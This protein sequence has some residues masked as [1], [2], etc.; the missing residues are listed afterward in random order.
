M[1]PC[2]F[3]V[4]YDPFLPLS[5]DF[6]S[7]TCD[8]EI[9]L[10]DVICVGIIHGD[11][12]PANFLAFR[13]DQSFVAKLADFGYSAHFKGSEFIRLAESRPFN[14]PEY[15]HGGFQ[16]DGARKRDIFSLGM[17]CLWILF[18]DVL[19]ET[20]GSANQFHV[21]SRDT[22]Q[23]PWKYG[24]LGQLK[25]E[26][27]L[28]AFGRLLVHQ[29]PNLSGRQKVALNRFL[30]LALAHDPQKRELNMAMLVEL[31]GYARYGLNPA[32]S[33]MIRI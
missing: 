13:E 23:D 26:K 12:K 25:Q 24:L 18:H 9:A 21:I 28:E 1:L 11:V 17:S 31:L 6:Q 27:A 5:P 10:S 33:M 32:L 15:Q 29:D 8:I 7:L 14:A 19:Q 20:V 2:R 3:R 16:F 22:L 30:E 4:V